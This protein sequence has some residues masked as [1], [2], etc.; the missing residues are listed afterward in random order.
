[1]MKSYLSLVPISA[2][3]HKKQNRMTIICIILAVFLVT[4]IFSMADMELRSQKVRAIS[5]YGNWHICLKN[6]TKSDAQIISARPDVAA[7]SWYNVLNY[8]LKDDYDIGGK[9][10]AVCGIEE[11]LVKFLWK[12][13][14][15]EGKYPSYNQVLLTEN[16]REVLNIHIGDSVEIRIPSGEI[17]KFTVSGFSSN[18][19]MISKADAI[20]VF[21]SVNTFEKF[22]EKATAKELK[23]SDL[24]YYIQFREH[25]NIKKSI[26]NIEESYDLTKENIGK[27]TAL[28]GV[29]GVSTD[30][31]VLGLYVVASILFLLV[32]AAGVL[33]I[34]SSMNSNIAQ[35]TEF[36][37]ML[38]CIG[39][40]KKQI[41]RFVYLEA[42]NWCKTAIPI[43]VGAG[44]I[45][46]WILCAI[47][48]ILSEK[49]FAQMPVFG[50]SKIGI[51]AGVII[52][53]L[54][55][56]LAARSPAKRATKVS[57]L[58]AVS[59]NMGQ[60]KNNYE[61]INMTFLKIDISLGIRH[62]WQSKKNFFL[63]V[64]SFSLS[65]ILFLT[66]STLVSFMNHAITPLRPYT[67]D[68]SIV[69][70][71]NTCSI[72][73]GIIEELMKIKGVKAVFGRSFAYD[74]P[75]KIRGEKKKIM[76]ISYDERQF[77]WA[78]EEN[79]LSDKSKPS[80]KSGIKEVA[81]DEKKG[82]VLT[83]YNTKNPLHRGDKIQAEVGNLTVMGTLSHC[84]FDK[85]EGEEIVICSEKLFQKLTGE[86]KYTIIDIQIN[87]NATEKEIAAIRKLAGE[88]I[89]SDSRLSNREAKG[90]YYSFA[91][92]IYGFLAV[93]AIIAMFNIMN[94]IS[95]SVSA[96]RKQYG[97]MR[98][99]GMSITQLIRMIVAEAMTYA[100]CGSVVG[101]ILG[102][103]LQRFLFTQLVTARWGTRWSMPIVTII[104][105]ILF[106]II[107][108][109]IAVYKP[110]AQI[111]DMSI[112]DAVHAE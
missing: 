82:Y 43:G 38:R 95:M 25:C 13:M 23:D 88:N 85:T 27:N 64:G 14:L 59:G 44:I 112:T 45:I 55:V 104:V 76:L 48:R 80:D 70:K 51:M 24:V 9:K 91:I 65:I 92:F 30:S 52:G 35:R 67:P 50:V 101:C 93:I 61:A 12:D 42:L 29:M 109:A 66:F 77:K 97:A 36:F 108:S 110:T 16:A 63:M 22:Y 7:S 57:P 2:K 41:M 33:M 3:I 26:K 31:Y 39:A 11:E 53:I 102:L 107:T 73:R 46:T 37:G 10:V 100:I 96:R 71:E 99:V 60:A 81:E 105:V 20:A 68:L 78:E 89:F 86:K 98:A 8:R 1:M 54:T 21:M 58:V 6:I 94:S 49:Y 83:S 74:I 84:P 90:T 106:V 62:A 15:V 18:N 72:D 32:L 5:E 17:A 19:M 56:F 4:A 28:L 34:A 47:L 111:R 75:A 79:K 87:K 69:S 103:P 40:D